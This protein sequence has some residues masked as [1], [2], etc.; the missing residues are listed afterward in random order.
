MTHIYKQGLGVPVFLYTI[1]ESN[2]QN[3]NKQNI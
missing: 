2:K 1:L 3:K